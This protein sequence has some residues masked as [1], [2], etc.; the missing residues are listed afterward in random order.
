MRR[1]VGGLLCAASALGVEEG[2]ELLGER[3]VCLLELVVGGVV[4]LC[5]Q[6]GAFEGEARVAGRG[7]ALLV[8]QEVLL[9]GEGE[10]VEAVAGVDE[11]SARL[12]AVRGV[13][14]LVEH[15]LELRLGEAAGR[16]EGD[17]LC[18]A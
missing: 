10:G 1:G 17:L 12:V 2:G 6:E 16:G 7:A 15:A 14:G 5:E 8:A 13:A 9:R 18:A 4:A 3:L 11:V